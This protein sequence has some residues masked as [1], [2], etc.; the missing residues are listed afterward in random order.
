MPHK[1]HHHHG[2]PGT[3][4]L[5]Q[6]QMCQGSAAIHKL[7]S[8]KGKRGKH[9][10]Q[11]IMKHNQGAFTSLASSASSFSEIMDGGAQPTEVLT[12]QGKKE[13]KN[14]RDR[15][16]ERRDDEY[17]RLVQTV[18]TEKNRNNYKQA[19]ANDKR[20]PTHN[21][22][23]QPQQ[24]SVEKVLVPPQT[25]MMTVESGPQQNENTASIQP[26]QDYHQSDRSGST[27]SGGLGTPKNQLPLRGTENPARL[28][29]TGKDMPGWQTLTSAS[30]KQNDNLMKANVDIN[31]VQQQQE[32]PNQPE[33]RTEVG[34]V[35][36]A[37]GK[38]GDLDDTVDDYVVKLETL[39]AMR[40]VVMQQ[41]EALK[42]MSTQNHTYR[43]KLGVAQTKFHSFHQQQMDQTSMIERLQMEKDSF[44]SEALVLRE[45]NNNIRQ[46]LERLRYHRVQYA[47][48]SNNLV[49]EFPE[50]GHQRLQELVQEKKHLSTTSGTSIPPENADVPS[51]SKNADKDPN[52][53][54]QKPNLPTSITIDKHN[55]TGDRW[56]FPIE[57]D[58]ASQV[59]NEMQ[60]WNQTEPQ[61]GEV[62]VSPPPSSYPTGSSKQTYLPPPLIQTPSN[63]APDPPEEKFTEAGFESTPHETRN[64]SDSHREEYLKDMAFVRALLS[65]YEKDAEDSFE[66]AE[67]G[68]ELIGYSGSGFESRGDQRSEPT[69]Q[70]RQN[71][72]GRRHQKHYKPTSDQNQ[73]QIH[74]NQKIYSQKQTFGLNL[75]QNQGHQDQPTNQ[76]HR[77]Q[78]TYDLSQHSQQNETPSS[79]ELGNL[80]LAPR[81]TEITVV[82]GQAGYDQS[83][84]SHDQNRAN[85]ATVEGGKG[86]RDESWNRTSPES[87]MHFPARGENHRAKQYAKALNQRRVLE[88]Q[89]D[90]ANQHP[91]GSMSPLNMEVPSRMM[92]EQNPPENRKERISKQWDEDY[93]SV[94]TLDQDR[95]NNNNNLGAAPFSFQ[96]VQTMPHDISE[97]DR[98]ILT[99]A[100]YQNR[101]Q[102]QR[103]KDKS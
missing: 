6:Q 51:C 81:A 12:N 17:R 101:V 100:V 91:W 80:L 42:A 73:N 43:R 36:A 86:M 38:V 56:H 34:R 98:R 35:M 30:A 28:S 14:Q 44:E 20:P 99:A 29:P 75:S 50:A 96:K 10:H 37:L 97:E 85:L 7:L 45:E 49:N 89:K 32:Q 69:P 25:M 18:I 95:E 54:T 1:N 55:D 4:E 31:M 13:E 59:T 19:S 62:E 9:D 93:E 87:M 3:A 47:T 22:K 26:H 72:D 58:F 88:S 53:T 46:E 83:Q 94:G 67:H 27:G 11:Q 5:Q 65:K 77:Q 15:D 64:D 68:D 90:L 78:Q 23:N 48:G 63:Y 74:Q 71:N 66:E 2:S 33:G 82:S 40:D 84:Y 60:P 21:I 76:H 79:R 92:Q 52:T 102:R 39:R 57:Q 61:G 70:P 103:R 16:R 8:K 41:Q 24:R